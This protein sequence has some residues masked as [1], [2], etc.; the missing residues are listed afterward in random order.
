MRR[1]SLLLVAAAAL[2]QA[3]NCSTPPLNAYPYCNAG[4]PVAARVD[5]LVRRLTL[6]ESAQVLNCASAGV[7]RLGLPPIPCGENLHGALSRCGAPWTDGGY[8]SSGCPTSLPHALA[9][10]AAFNRTLWRMYGGLLGLESRA[11]SQQT[12]SANSQGYGVGGTLV[13]FTPNIK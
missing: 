11:L 12:A 3:L 4:L 13:A 1:T 6:N 10:A 5:D 9:A 7:P 8:T 2:G